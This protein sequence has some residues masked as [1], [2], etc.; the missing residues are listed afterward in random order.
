VFISLSKSFQVLF[1]LSNF[2][3]LLLVLGVILLWTRRHAWG[4]LL[5]TVITLVFLAIAIL[6]IGEFLAWPLERNFTTVPIL[7]ERVDGII[8]SCGINP[9][10]TLE[11][12]QPAFTDEGETLTSAVALARV[13]P[14]A[15]LVFS[16]GGSSLLY[17]HISEASAA[18]IFFAEQGIDPSRL[19]FDDKSRGTMEKAHHCLAMIKPP[20]SATWILIASAMRMPRT[21]AAFQSVGWDILPYPVD[22]R[23]PGWKYLEFNL[24]HS[25]TLTWSALKEWLGLVAYRLSGQTQAFF[26]R[27]SSGPA[28]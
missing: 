2:L 21:L 16:G 17:P 6:P 3:L 5:V 13:Y 8:T 12:G 10:L 25:L 19:H 7:P 9:F 14:A 26:P 22:H 20:A 23:F 27:T 1:R 18:A 28:R 4:R 15:K 11:S 24:D